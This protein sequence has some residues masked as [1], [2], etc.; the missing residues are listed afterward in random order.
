MAGPCL[1]I[2]YSLAMICLCFRLPGQ[3]MF[4]KLA[5]HFPFPMA[6]SNA[7]LPDPTYPL[8]HVLPLHDVF[9]K[10]LKPMEIYPSLKL[11]FNSFSRFTSSATN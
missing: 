10:P 6:F 2:A 11:Q 7:F 9:P 5:M 8:S 3:M 1:P 4:S